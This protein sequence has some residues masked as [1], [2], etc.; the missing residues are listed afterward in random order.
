M[1]LI[2]IKLVICYIKY[3][4]HLKLMQLIVQMFKDIINNLLDIKLL[5][6]VG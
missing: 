1:N 6:D 3:I 2:L 5:K 4:W